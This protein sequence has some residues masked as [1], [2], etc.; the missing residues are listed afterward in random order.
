LLKLLYAGDD[1][2]WPSLVQSNCRA[3]II[4]CNDYLDMVEEYVKRQEAKDPKMTYRHPMIAREAALQRLGEAGRHELYKKILST[5]GYRQE[6]VEMASA[7]AGL[8]A[9]DEGMYDLVPLIGTLAAR[10]FGG[11]QEELQLRLQI[12]Y[13]LMAPNAAERL[14]ELVRD[15]VKSDVACQRGAKEYRWAMPCNDRACGAAVYAIREIRKLNPPRVSDQL[16][17]MLSEYEAVRTKGQNALQKRVEAAR[18]EGIPEFPEWQPSPTA[19][20]GFLGP[21]IAKL[22]GDLGNR[23][24]ERQALGEKTLWDRVNEVEKEMVKRHLVT[25]AETVTQA[26][27]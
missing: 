10:L 24:I 17:E 16:K 25:E 6:G 8:R 19:H 12:A 21:Q 18:K 27:E 9:L 26:K 15:G 11:S 5:P 4:D 1:L 22:V 7:E 23:E 3:G 13:C 2:S 20:L 14:L